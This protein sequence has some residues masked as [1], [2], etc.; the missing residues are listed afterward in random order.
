MSFSYTIN[1]S[2]KI[3]RAVAEGTV[4]VESC[5][6]IMK[7]L[8]D[9]PA[10]KPDYNIFVDLRKMDY[11]PSNDELEEI[12]ATLATLKEVYKSKIALLVEGKIQLFIAKLACLL[13]KRSR[14]KIEPFTEIEQAES[15]LKLED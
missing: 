12:I 10:F 5:I 13:S 3:A 4:N 7:R 11:L 9:D 6:E 8:A 2:E 15:Y 1:Q 14:F